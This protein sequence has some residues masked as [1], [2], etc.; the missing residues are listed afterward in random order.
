MA[1][2]NKLP[3]PEIIKLLDLLA[4][5]HVNSLANNQLYVYVLV[6]LEKFTD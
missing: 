5:F 4:I 6:A 3:L 2:L 1:Q